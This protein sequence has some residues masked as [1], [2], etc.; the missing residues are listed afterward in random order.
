MNCVDDFTLLSNSKSGTLGGG[1]VPHEYANAIVYIERSC[2]LL[3]FHFV[4]FTKVLPFLYLRGL[5]I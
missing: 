1:C 3:L 5:K 2:S 4:V